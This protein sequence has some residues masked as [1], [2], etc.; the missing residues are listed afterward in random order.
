M[1][2]FLHAASTT[3]V[4]VDVA[5]MITTTTTTTV[6]INDF[7]RDDDKWCYK[8]IQPQSSSFVE[9]DP[10]PSLRVQTTTGT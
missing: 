9:I 10:L 7:L 6:L 1:L 3:S 4:H 8:R 2:P 5:K